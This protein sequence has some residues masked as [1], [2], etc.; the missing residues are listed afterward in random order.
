MAGDPLNYGEEWVEI[1]GFPRYMIS[2]EGRIFNKTTNRYMKWSKNN[3]GHSKISLL[4]ETGGRHDRSVSHLVAKHCVKKPNADCDRVIHL[5][6]DHGDCRSENLA[7]RPRWFA[8]KYSHQLK[9]PQPAY[10]KNLPVINLSDNKRYENII[11]AGKDEGLLFE[12]I[13]HATYTGFSVYPTGSRWEVEKR[14]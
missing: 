2:T 3:Y 11:E 12:H 8:W 14:V 13:W 7:W 10:Y 1:E 5:N 9:V 4:T 6:G